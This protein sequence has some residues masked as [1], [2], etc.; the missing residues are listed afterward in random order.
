[1]EPD[2]TIESTDT[3][4]GKL[5]HFGPED[6]ETGWQ[7]AVPET[8]ERLV[9]LPDSKLSLT[10][11]LFFTGQKVELTRL[12]VAA[13]LGTALATRDLF[14]LGLPEI[15]RK[16]SLSVIPEAHRWSSVS[17]AA[18]T[19]SAA[20]FRDDVFYA[21]LYWFEYAIHGNPRQA[22]MTALNMPRSTANVY[23]RRLK[24]DF[25]LPGTPLPN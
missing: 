14:Q 22:I 8:F 25:E 16:V 18:D 6:P 4:D 2:I 15:I 20:R 17:H 9:R 5:I 23:L 21:Q 1:M 11:G 12:C 24:L 3:P 10:M 19:A 13:S 7:L